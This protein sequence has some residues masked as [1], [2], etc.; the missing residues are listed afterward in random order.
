MKDDYSLSQLSKPSVS[1]LDLKK[2]NQF[3]VWK[4]QD[5]CSKGCSSICQ[6]CLGQLTPLLPAWE[7]QQISWIS[8]QVVPHCDCEIK[9]GKLTLPLQ[10]G[11]KNTHSMTRQITGATSVVQSFYTW[12]QNKICSKANSN[13]HHQYWNIIFLSETTPAVCGWINRLSRH[14]GVDAWLWVSV[15][16]SQLLSGFFFFFTKTQGENNQEQVQFTDWVTADVSH[17][18]SLPV[19]R[20]W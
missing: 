9:A 4:Y 2:K 7:I 13:M 19:L 18:F 1:V 20:K 17:C 8:N 11:S 6:K 5:V 12:Y 10:W 14:R 15:L 16:Q 3:N